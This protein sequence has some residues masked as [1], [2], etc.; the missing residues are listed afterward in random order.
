[1]IDQ[2]AVDVW[3]TGVILY[4]LVTG[5][6]PFEDPDDPECFAQVFKNIRKC[7]LRPLPAHV[8][9]GCR[10]LLRTIFEVDPLKRILLKNL[11]NNKWLNEQARIYADGIGPLNV[12][13]NTPNYSIKNLML[14]LPMHHRKQVGRKRLCVITCRSVC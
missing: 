5:T 9:E 13:E 2:R 1:M 4:L 14:Q 12:Q 10:D 7:N 6:Y 11:V 8:S 3:A